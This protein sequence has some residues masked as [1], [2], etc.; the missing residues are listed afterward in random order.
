MG[1]RQV[2]SK[3]EKEAREIKPALRETGASA[4]GSASRLHDIVA[5]KDLFASLVGVETFPT[6]QY[7][8][9][10]QGG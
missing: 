8:D 7:R 1:A 2:A 6:E 3:T 4:Q 5:A 9:A 10:D